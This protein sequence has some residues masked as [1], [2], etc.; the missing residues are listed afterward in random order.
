[1][2]ENGNIYRPM[3]WPTGRADMQIDIGFN[4]SDRFITDFIDTMLGAA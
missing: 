3:A 1:M 4:P 2:V